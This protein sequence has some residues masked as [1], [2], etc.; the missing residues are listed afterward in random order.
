MTTAEKPQRDDSIEYQIAF[1]KKVFRLLKMGY[2][3]LDALSFKDAEEE[4]I[5]GEI[6]KEIN[7]IRDD[8]NAP[9]WVIFFSVHEDPKINAPGRRGK[10]RKR[11]DIE[12]ERN[13]RGVSP[14][15]Q[16]EA[17]RLSTN[18]HATMGKY[19]GPEGLG[20]F[21][22]GSYACD[23]FEAGMIGYI[24]SETP[25]SWAAKAQKTFEKD[26]EKIEVAPDGN[27]RG[28]TIID[29]LPHCFRSR[30]YKTI[31]KYPITIYHAFLIFC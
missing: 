5:T 10:Q 9:S 15:Y 28:V 23:K 2:D 13:C 6:V 16:F 20:E 3:R 8:R 7:R 31:E 25:E 27:W 24:Q 21:L 12:F 14:R 4:D 26:P 11:V 1:R 19:L 18:T 17:K 30:H 22:S 29:D